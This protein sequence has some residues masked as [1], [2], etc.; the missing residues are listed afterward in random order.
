[1][2]GRLVSVASNGERKYVIYYKYGLSTSHIRILK[3]QSC[4]VGAQGISV[5]VFHLG[6]HVA[7]KEPLDGKP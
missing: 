6:P 7:L 3:E 1:M 5:L 2:F 4:L